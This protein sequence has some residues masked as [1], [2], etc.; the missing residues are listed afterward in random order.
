MSDG[1]PG[2]VSPFACAMEAVKA[3]KRPEHL[4][5]ARYLFNRVV[6]IR[7][8]ANGFAFQLQ[9]GS[10]L[11]TKLGE[12][13][14]LERLCC[15]FFGFALEVEPEGAATWLKLTGREGVKPF[16]R[17]EIGEFLGGPWELKRS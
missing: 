12:F 9:P 1:E 14:E 8:L 16:I 11:L 6:E 17:A 7:V 5:N 3:G 4:A 10:G 15:P 2:S 13:I